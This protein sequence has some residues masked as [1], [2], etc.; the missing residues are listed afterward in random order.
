MVADG[1]DPGQ[2]GGKE[3]TVSWELGFELLCIKPYW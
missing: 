1:N 2:S 3:H